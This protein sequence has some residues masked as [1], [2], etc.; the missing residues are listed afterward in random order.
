LPNAACPGLHWKPLVA[1]IGQLLTLYYPGSRQDNNQQNN[2]EKIMHI[3][4][5]FD[6]HGGVLVQYCAHYLMEEDH[7]FL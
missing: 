4:G 1:A 7:G 6:G 5:R 2:N 3:A